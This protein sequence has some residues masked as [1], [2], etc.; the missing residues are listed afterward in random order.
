MPMVARWPGKIKP[1]TVSDFVIAF[2]DVLPTLCEIAGATP[3]KDIDGISFL[4][5]LLGREQKKTHEYFY[6]EF[7][8]YGGQQA[9]RLGDWKGVRRQMFKGN[10]KIE[11]YN[12]KDDIGEKHDV[13]AQHPEIVAKIR[14]IMHDAR[15][16]SKEFPFKPLDKAS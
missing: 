10:M 3:P 2:W 6:W 12:L 1:G 5:T 11:L 8:S 14:K 7:P 13:A 15:T 9:V 16:P 4:P